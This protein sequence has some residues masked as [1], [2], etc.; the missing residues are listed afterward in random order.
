MSKQDFLSNFRIARNLFVHPRVATDSSH[1]DPHELEQKL[2]RAAIWL[3]P[4]SVRGFNASDFPELGLDRQKELQSAV[5]DFLEVANQVPPNKPATTE[6]YGKAAAAFAKM[7]EI[8][9]PYLAKPDEEKVIADAL[10]S[11]ELPPWVVNWDYE[12]G[13]DADEEPVVWVTIF[14]EDGV[15]SLTEYARMASRLEW[16]LHQAL[17]AA[18]MSV[19]PFVK[20]W[21]AA[22]HKSL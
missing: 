2:A 15:A 4:R 6:Q 20:V 12:L 16:T 7:L 11:T 8:L 5:R 10:R 18:D 17:S 9:D 3:T 22:E 21:T 13:R 19:W 14:V 1:L